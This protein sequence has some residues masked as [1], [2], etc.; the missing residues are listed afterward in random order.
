MANLETLQQKVNTVDQLLDPDKAPSSLSA[1][2]CTELGI[3]SLT[4]GAIV[5]DFKNSEKK[6]KDIKKA[7]K[8]LDELENK[9]TKILKGRKKRWGIF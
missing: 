2:D 3:M 6:N 9:A 4:S 1:E 5:K 8:S 7:L